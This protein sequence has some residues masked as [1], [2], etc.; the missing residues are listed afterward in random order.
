[1]EFLY[2]I[3]YACLRLRFLDVETNPSPRRPVPAVCGIL[4][5]NL[6][7]LAGNL[8]DLT[9]ASYQYDILFCSES[10][11]SDMRHVSELLFPG[12]GRPVLLARG[13]TARNLGPVGWLH[14]YEMVS[15]HLAN[16][17]LSVVVEMLFFRFVVWNRTFMCTV[18]SQP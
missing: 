18:L 17:N 15:E 5:S 6:Q 8:S 3:F 4:C 14:T 1:M 16:P 12:F 7:G 2:L 13:F 9:V 10:L 11:D